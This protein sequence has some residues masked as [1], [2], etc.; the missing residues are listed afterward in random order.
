MTAGRRLAGWLVLAQTAVALL[1]GALFLLLRGPQS[2]F[3]ALGGGFAVV[4]GTAGM[5]ACGLG[6]A[7]AGGGTMLAR[8]LAGMLLKWLVVFGG[9]SL[10]MF[11]LHLPAL[12][13][14]VGMTAALLTH[15]AALW[16]A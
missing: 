16:R 15:V 13:V 10:L 3:A 2:G 11:R 6:G 9:I 5:A 12:P 14:L 7:V 8:M 4:L 1:A